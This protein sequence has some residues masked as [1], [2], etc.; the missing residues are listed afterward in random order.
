[1]IL[2]CFE[3]GRRV[4]GPLN[5]WTGRGWVRF[6]RG[7]YYD[8]LYIKRNTVVCFIMEILGGIAPASARH[9]RRLAEEA[10]KPGRRDGT[11]Y[12]SWTARSFYIHF[13]QR[14]S[15]AAVMEDA[16][17]INRGARFLR[18]RAARMQGVPA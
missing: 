16:K 17:I 14:L 13:A 1:M 2:G 18:Q 6:R 7:Q 3:S 5:H 8:A 10:E 11:V 4:D 12:S 9:L 15:C